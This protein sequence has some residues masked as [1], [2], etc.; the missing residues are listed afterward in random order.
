MDKPLQTGDR[1]F[2]VMGSGQAY[3][4]LLYLGA[5]F[6]LGVFYFVYLVTG[7][8]LGISLSIIWIGIPILML[9][10]AGWWA[11]A[12]FERLMA[13][14]LLKEDIPRMASP[15][16]EDAD[17]WTRVKEF[18][19]NPITWRS[20]LYLFAKFPLGL[21]TFVVLVTIVALT[22]GFLTMPFT[23]QF[24]EYF[25]GGV[26]FGLGLPAWQIDSL[27]DALLGALIG[28]MMWPVALHVINGLA[29]VHAKF[30]KIMFS[31]D[32]VGQLR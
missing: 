17:I 30:A 21:G 13:V 8:S 25:Q 26:S 22:L 31:V 24:A 10:G 6:P 15:S 27:G 14:N 9:V 2:K 32:P 5:A 4:N 3:L 11:L 18:F 23:Y 7:L 16:E 12:N 19:T 20:L 1:F 28:L 29:W